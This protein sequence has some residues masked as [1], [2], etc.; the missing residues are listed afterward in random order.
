MWRKEAIPQEFKAA[1]MV[2]LFKRKRKGIPQ[3][4]DNHRGISSWFIA[5]KILARVLNW[6]NNTLNSQGFYQKVN[7]DLRRTGEKLACLHSKTASREMPGTERGPLHD[8]CWPYQSV[9]HRQSWETVEKYDTVWLSGQI[10]SSGAA[11]PRW[12]SCTGQND[13]EFSDLFPMRNGVKQGCVAPTLFSMM[14]L[15]S[16]WMLSRMVTMVYLAGIFWLE[17]FQ[18]D[19]C[20]LNPRCRQ[21]C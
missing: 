10:H 7:V 15:P 3:V 19:G 13:G 1:S 20:K 17:A 12:Y 9:S 11:V 6:L 5:G 18:P 2:H 8:V 14:F 16:S 4:C 21:S